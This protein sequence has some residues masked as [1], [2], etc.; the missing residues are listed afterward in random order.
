MLA[1]PA[2]LA[3]LVCGSCTREA[4]RRLPNVVIYLVDTLRADHL[5]VYGYAR[6]TSP[7]LD[8]WAEGAVVYDRAYSPTS[9]TRTATV[10]L[11]SGLDPSSH[12]VENRLDVIP[13]DVRLL[14]QVLREQGYATSAVVTN[15][16]VLPIWG[17]ERGFDSFVDLE[18]KKSS[19]TAD[20]VVAEL[21]RQLPALAGDAPFLLY[22]HLLDPHHPYAP[23][24]PFDAKFR[25]ESDSKLQANLD[26]YDGEIAFGDSQFERFIAALKANGVY[27]DTLVVFVSDHGE[28]FHEHGGVQ[29]GHTLYDEVVRV[30]LVVRFP[31]GEH[32]GRR[33]SAPVSLIDVVP[34]VLAALG[35]PALEG[36]DGT[37][38][39]PE[40]DGAGDRPL[41]LSLNLM[42]H[43]NLTDT[44]RGVLRGETKFLRRVRPEARVELYDVSEDPGEARNRA[45]ESQAEVERF[46]VE[47]D[48]YLAQHSTGV[49]LRVLNAPG[50]RAD[51]CEVRLRTDGRFEA[52]F[53]SVSI[54]E[55]D[56]IELTDDGRR[57][58]LRCDLAIR[59]HPTGDLPRFL[60][61][62][63]GLVFRVSPPDAEITVESVTLDS[64]RPM[65]LM[66]GAARVDQRL[67][68]TFR[69]TDAAW[70]VKDVEE[71]LREQGTPP[72]RPPM[73]VYVAVVSPSSLEEE[74]PG[75][76]ESRLRALGYIEDD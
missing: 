13:E 3:A 76:V 20:R 33:V 67:P 12:R 62:E 53:T 18:A 35:L 31:G 64:G 49:H 50:W 39:S 10:S 8:R 16:N 41:H 6:D 15:V 58:H 74:L 24:A 1:V 73:G 5:G 71:L 47:L 32:A 43:V 65:P 22:A 44:I 21:E 52:D 45:P 14:S 34:T 61:D 70:N 40:P 72:E 17:F 59:P 2:A 38:L 68:F 7:A 19:G 57:L 48:A 37:A 42:W 30:P 27:E 75:E 56:G 26:A 51:G 46:A 4:P 29:H 55:G 9:W 23:P 54:E 36:V 69:A 25:G 66:A 63:D 28:E 60:T 11:L